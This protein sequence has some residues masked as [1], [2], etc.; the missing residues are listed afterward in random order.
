MNWERLGVAV[1]ASC[2]KRV[3]AT[4]QLWMDIVKRLSS[5]RNNTTCVQEALRPP[6]RALLAAT[7]ILIGA[8]AYHTPC[9]GRCAHQTLAAKRVG[10][11]DGVTRPPR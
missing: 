5:A 2:A 4:S 9:A 7:W 6:G 11:R 1:L 3:N 8:S 10:G